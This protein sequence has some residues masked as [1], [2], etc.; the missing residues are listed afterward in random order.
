MGFTACGS[1]FSLHRMVMPNRVKLTVKINTVFGPDWFQ[2]LG[3]SHQVIQSKGGQLV[4][5]KGTQCDFKFSVKYHL[6]WLQSSP[7]T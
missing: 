2:H 7:G 1:M 4:L 6:Q 3:R 5:P